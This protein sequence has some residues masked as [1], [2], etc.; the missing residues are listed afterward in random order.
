MIAIFILSFCYVY[1]TCQFALSSSSSVR[2]YQAPSD[3]EA[4]FPHRAS[5]PRRCRHR[6]RDHRLSTFQ[7]NVLLWLDVRPFLLLCLF[8]TSSMSRANVASHVFPRGRR[9]FFLARRHRV[10][11]SRLGSRTMLALFLS[12]HLSS[13]GEQIRHPPCSMIEFTRVVNSLCL[14]SSCFLSPLEFK[15]TFLHISRSLFNANTI[16]ELGQ[17]F[18]T[19]HDA[20]AA[21]PRWRLLCCLPAKT[22][23]HS[24][25]STSLNGRSCSRSKFSNRTRDN[26]RI[27]PLWRPGRLSRVK[28]SSSSPSSPPQ[29]HR[30][31]RSPVETVRRADPRFARE[32][33]IPFSPSSS[34]SSSLPVPS[35]PAASLSAASS[36][37][38]LSHPLI[39]LNACSNALFG[40]RSSL[41]PVLDTSD[42][43]PSPATPCARNRA[44]RVMTSSKALQHLVEITADPTRMLASKSRCGR[45]GHASATSACA[46]RALMSTRRSNRTHARARAA[47]M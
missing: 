9:C 37:I 5:R 11:N 15:P 32:P 33:T 3:S 34:S 19:S 44:K 13:D 40:K 23:A 17:A 10:E 35:L 18:G 28:P 16:C 42:T 41:R 43:S 31:A 6:R 26:S 7:P 29:T 21:R 24:S 1:C 8:R 4:R 36:P 46:V 47:S 38:T 22:N 39:T 30:L 45:V 14:T 2:T 25:L 27:L 12:V 20:V